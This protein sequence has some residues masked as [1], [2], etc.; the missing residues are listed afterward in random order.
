[1]HED[2]SVHAEVEQQADVGFDECGLLLVGQ[3]VGLEHGSAVGPVPVLQR[4]ITVQLI[5]ELLDLVEAHQPPS[6]GMVWVSRAMAMFLV[7]M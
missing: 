4:G 3:R 7:S 1:M 5:E 6:F 2:L